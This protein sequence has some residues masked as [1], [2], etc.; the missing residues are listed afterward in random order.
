MHI[1]IISE[2]KNLDALSL[3]GCKLIKFKGG[4]ARMFL[5]AVEVGKIIEELD[6]KKFKLTVIP[7]F[8]RR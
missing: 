2:D 8:M 7:P 6:E 3:P 5:P 1:E 4:I